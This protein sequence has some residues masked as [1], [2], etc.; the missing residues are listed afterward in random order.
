MK[1]LIRRVLLAALL[2]AGVWV[3]AAAQQAEELSLDLTPLRKDFTT[4]LE[5]LG[6]EIV[7]YLHQAALSG[8]IVGEAQLGPFPR[9]SV[10][11]LSAGST[12]SDG[13]GAFIDPANPELWALEI[14]RIPELIQELVDGAGEAAADLYDTTKR[15]FAY[16]ALRFGFGIG[17]AHGFEVLVNGFYLPK[18]LNGPLFGLVEHD[19][20]GTLHALEP[21]F[22]ML[23]AS[24]MIRKVILSE[25]KGSLRPAL[26]AG[27]GYTY[28]HFRL[29]MTG[30]DLS[31]VTEEPI[32]FGG[33]GTL[34]MN[35]TIAL[36]TSSHTGG[37][38]LHLSKRLLVF[39]PYIKFGSWFHTARYAADAALTATVTNE[40]AAAQT[41]ILTAAETTYTD[42]SFLVTGGLELKIFSFILS[43]NLSIDLQDSEFSPGNFSLEELSLNR[44][45]VNLG[46]RLQF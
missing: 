12:F 39:T 3:P 18:A 19:T 2:A 32:D 45:T 28:A 27:A 11:L 33:M 23:T 21:E 9:F 20:D 35:G 41:D 24:F 1:T 10:T 13:I 14:F 26:S 34:G 30:F 29:A 7:P 40:Q 46:A 25:R 43:S 6:D 17:I 42:F 22:E 4:L 36:E 31:A 16:P 38:E 8:N 5:G 44:V 37:V 15:I